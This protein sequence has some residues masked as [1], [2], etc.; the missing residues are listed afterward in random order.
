MNSS[1]AKKSNINSITP[2]SNNTNG[3]FP[4][5]LNK[6]Y[7]SPSTEKLYSA[8][9]KNLISN[10]KLSNKDLKK[11]PSLKINPKYEQQGNK[12]TKKYLYIIF[13]I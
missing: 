2:T 4:Q 13:L 8:I 10:S 3:N 12:F 9:P 7:K 5:F 11:S 1:K 6:N